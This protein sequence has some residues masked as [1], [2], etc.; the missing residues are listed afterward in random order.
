MAKEIVLFSSE[1]P[2]SLES[3]AAFLRQLA[4]R[5]TD[6]GGEVVLRKGAEEFRMV[7]P[8]NIV[9]ELK[10]EKEE[11]KGGTKHSFEIEI[12]WVEGEESGPVTLG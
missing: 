6:A 8:P 4:D 10:A 11:K 2:K 5:F 1:E 9:L 7:I 12:E 3:T